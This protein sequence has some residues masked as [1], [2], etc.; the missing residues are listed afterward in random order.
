M[1]L[2]EERMDL[3]VVK[4]QSGQQG[5]VHHPHQRNATPGILLAVGGPPTTPNIA[6]VP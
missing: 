3:F 5:L 4:G 2:G 1:W 6:M